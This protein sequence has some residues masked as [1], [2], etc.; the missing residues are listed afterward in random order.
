MINAFCEA[1]FGGDGPLSVV[2]LKGGTAP[3]IVPSRAEALLCGG[4]ALLDEVL[5]VVRRWKGPEGSSS[6]PFP[7]RGGSSSSRRASR[8]HGSMPE[9]GVN[10][11]AC[12]F[13]L[14][15]GLPL[16]G[17]QESLVEAFNALIGRETDGA[18]RGWPSPTPFRGP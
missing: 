9:K 13:D 16:S 17:E 2:S 11:I 10:A 8:A 6:R 3:N 1:P 18:S 7:G 14:L 15:G 12:L 5:D 4:A